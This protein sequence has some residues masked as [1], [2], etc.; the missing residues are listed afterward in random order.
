MYDRLMFEHQGL[1]NNILL[2]EKY[3][4]ECED[5]VERKH[6]TYQ[7]QA[8]NDYRSALESRIYLNRKK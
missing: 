2:T 8:M 4:S 3:L 6:I 7:L 5:E 1:I